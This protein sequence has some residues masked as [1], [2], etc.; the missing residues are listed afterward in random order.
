MS[1][2]CANILTLLTRLGVSERPQLAPFA[3][4]NDRSH[5]S[6]PANAA[7]A[8]ALWDA[9]QS[10]SHRRGPRKRAE[11]RGASL[12]SRLR[13]I[14][15]RL[16]QASGEG[17]AFSLPGR[18]PSS[19]N[20]IRQRRGESTPR[21]RRYEGYGT[22]ATHDREGTTNFWR[23]DGGGAREAGRRLPGDEAVQAREDS[24]RIRAALRAVR[25]RRRSA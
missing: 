15:I 12:F 16:P 14:F 20:S 8:G 10:G 23:T 18:R 19:P 9:A 21:G 5:R 11:K 7:R 2:T 13:S 17:Q 4:L 3:S 1:Y 6:L 25:T 24:S 22:T